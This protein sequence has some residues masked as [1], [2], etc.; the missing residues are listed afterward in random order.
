MK[1]RSTLTKCVGSIFVIIFVF[2]L[3]NYPYANAAATKHDMGGLDSVHDCLQ[4]ITTLTGQQPVLRSFVQQQ[5]VERVHLKTGQQFIV[6]NIVHLVSF[7]DKQPFVFYNYVAYMS[8]A[9]YIKP[10]VI[11]LWADTLPAEN[12]TWW[13]KTLQQVPNIYSVFKKPYDRISGKKVIH[14]EHAS[15]V[16][17]LEVLR[18]KLLYVKYQINITYTYK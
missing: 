8:I 5:L 4:L 1:K 15:D 6:P 14:I 7:G 17:R 9:K 11:V 2:V 12:N 18:G 16:L 13:Q 3:Y 10:H